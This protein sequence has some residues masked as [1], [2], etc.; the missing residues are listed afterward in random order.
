MTSNKLTE[1]NSKMKE[2]NVMQSRENLGLPFTLTPACC[3]KYI[4]VKPSWK[5]FLE[6]V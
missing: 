5:I 1:G 3:A 2:M 4:Q 6:K